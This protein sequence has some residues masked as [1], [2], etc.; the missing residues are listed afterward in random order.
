MHVSSRATI[1]QDTRARSGR[2]VRIAD[3]K[4]DTSDVNLLVK[5]C[6][7]APLQNGGKGASVNQ[8][9]AEAVVADETG[10]IR[11]RCTEEQVSLLTQGGAFNICNARIAMYHG[12]M[13]L[14]VDRRG[15][16]EPAVE[17]EYWDFVPNST[18]NMST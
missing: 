12:H 5:T 4:P 11:M 2:F 3:L 8:W 6:K 9:V 18:N 7:V 16:V 1:Q 17:G 13:R 10:A 15:R 14:E